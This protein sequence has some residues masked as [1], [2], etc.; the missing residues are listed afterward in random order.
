MKIEYKMIKPESDDHSFFGFFV[1]SPIVGAD[2]IRPHCK[3]CVCLRAA[4]RRP[5]YTLLST[6]YSIADCQRQPLHRI[7]YKD[8]KINRIIL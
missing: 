4:E 2:I 8:Y 1:L 3:I 7:F 5:Y 6:L